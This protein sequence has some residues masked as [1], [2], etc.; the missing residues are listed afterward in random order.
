MKT[1]AICNE[2]FNKFVSF[3][4]TRGTCCWNPC[5]LQE[6][7]FLILAA[8]QPL[9]L[10]PK[11]TM[12]PFVPRTYHSKQMEKHLLEPDFCKRVEVWCYKSHHANATGH[13]WSDMFLWYWWQVGTSWALLP[14]HS[15]FKSHTGPWPHP[16]MRKTLSYLAPRAPSL[17]LP[18]TPWVSLLQD[19]PPKSLWIHQK[20]LPLSDLLILPGQYSFFK[21]IQDMV[22]SPRF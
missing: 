13:T 2:H 6:C 20:T 17:A 11:E 12:P 16:L 22:T 19:T 8:T 15:S 5:T 4:S 3:F 9:K 1:Y 7:P 21:I 14:R 10:P 18:P